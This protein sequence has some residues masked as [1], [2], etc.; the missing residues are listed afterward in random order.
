VTTTAS[1]TFTKQHRDGKHKRK[2]SLKG[3]YKAG[4]GSTQPGNKQHIGKKPHFR[5]H[6]FRNAA[7]NLQRVQEQAG[8]NLEQK[9]AYEKAKLVIELLDPDFAVGETYLVNFSHM[10]SRHHYVKKH[11]DSGDIT[12]QYIL[13][14]GEYT[15]DVKLFVYNKDG[16]FNQAYDCKDRILKVDGRLPHRVRKTP[17]FEGNRFAVIWYKSFDARITAPTPVLETPEFVYGA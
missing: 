11:V 1:R 8:L 15:G 16:S 5:M 9:I 6:N 10:N 7:V 2:F 13:S 12:Y 3:S 4:R 17:G 14:F